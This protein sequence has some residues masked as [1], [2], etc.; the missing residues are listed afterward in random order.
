MSVP[1]WGTLLAY[2]QALQIRI[3]LAKADHPFDGGEYSA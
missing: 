2:G 1:R 3:F